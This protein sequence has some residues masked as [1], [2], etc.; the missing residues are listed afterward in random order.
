MSHGD[1]ECEPLRPRSYLRN[2]SGLLDLLADAD[3]DNPTLQVAVLLALVIAER[4]EDRT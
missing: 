3:A 1:G 4:V 2:S